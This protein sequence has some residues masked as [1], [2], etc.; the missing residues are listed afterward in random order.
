[1]YET[2]YHIAPMVGAVAISK[3]A[4]LLDM[5][6]RVVPNVFKYFVYVT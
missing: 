5:G 1:M 2:K 6:M 4:S 3:M